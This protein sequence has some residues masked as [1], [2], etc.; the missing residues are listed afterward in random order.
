M[1]ESRGGIGRQEE[2]GLDLIQ[3]LYKDMKLS[4]KSL[5]TFC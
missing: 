1:E 5:K 4:I 3:T 2:C